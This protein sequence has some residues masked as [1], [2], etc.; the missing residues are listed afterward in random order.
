MVVISVLVLVAVSNKSRF[1]GG[2]RDTWTRTELRKVKVCYGGGWGGWQFR[3]L[4][5]L[6]VACRVDV[7]VGCL[8]A[9]LL[10]CELLTDGG[11]SSVGAAAVC[12]S[13]PLR[14]P[15]RFV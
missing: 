12:E 1:I 14:G 7:D 15:K 6:V 10:I 2:R 9:R 11:I 4:E 5:L 13:M 3:Q 8:S